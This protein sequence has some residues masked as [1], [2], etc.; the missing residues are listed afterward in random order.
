[1]KKANKLDKRMQKDIEKLSKAEERQEKADNAREEQKDEEQVITQKKG[2]IEAQEAIRKRGSN[3][4]INDT[5]IGV[6]LVLSKEDCHKMGFGPER[7]AKEVRAWVK[8]KLG[9]KA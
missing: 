4:S 5:K 7:K 2:V 8:E 6:T 1:M 3:L 9:L